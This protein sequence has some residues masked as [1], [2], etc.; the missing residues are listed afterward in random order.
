MRE[1][2]SSLWGSC[3]T[4]WP[5]GVCRFRATRR[6]RFSTRSST[7]HRSR[8]DASTRDLPVDLERIIVKALE[9]DRKLRYQSAAEMRADLAR[10]KRDSE[11]GRTAAMP[12]AASPQRERRLAWPWI[13]AAIALLAGVAGVAVWRSL[14]TDASTAPIM[15]F[16]LTMPAGERLSRIPGVAI[17]PDGRHVAY[18]GTDGS[19][20]RLFIRPLDSAQARPIERSEGASKPFFSPDNQWLGF[21]VGDEIRKV[22]IAGGAPITVITGAASGSGQSTGARRC[23]GGWLNHLRPGLWACAG[24]RLRR[25]SHAGD[26]SRRR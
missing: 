15:R 24:A 20:T 3:C 22:P 16:G 9:K 4:K 13:A 6:R 8:R 23:M 19:V 5:P 21:Q 12:A 25:R 7:R 10:L 2:T 14:S 18:V 26:A 11:S 1:A 17:S